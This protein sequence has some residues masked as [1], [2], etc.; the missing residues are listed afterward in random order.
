[1]PTVGRAFMANVECDKR[2][3]RRKEELLA[4][5]SRYNDLFIPGSKKRLKLVSEA[6]Q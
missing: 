1:M 5:L 6:I 2:A 4:A 3:C